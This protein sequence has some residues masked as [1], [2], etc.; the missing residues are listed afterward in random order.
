VT[1]SSA[2]RSTTAPTASSTGLLPARVPQKPSA[3]AGV[4]RATPTTATTSARRDPNQPLRV[5]VFGDSIAWTLMRYLP[6]TPGMTFTDRTAL[7]CGIAQ[8]GPYRYFGDLTDQRAECDAWPRTWKEQV[9]A[10]RPDLVLLLVGRWETMDRMHDGRWTHLGEPAYDSYLSGEIS[11]AMRVLRSSGA[12]LVVATEPY[13]R[14]GEQPDGTLFPEDDPARVDRWNTLL[15][16]AASAAGVSVLDLHS[17]LCP[18][19]KYTPSVDGL[20]VRSDGVHLTPDGVSWLTPWLV[21]S[22]R[23]ISR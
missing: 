21:G 16:S 20:R 7:G 4:T 5:A 15:R 6:A 9:T 8:G 3:S 12:Q 1:L 11:A 10:D 22:L 23:A 2:V 18:D 19:G 14:R 13:N 17:K